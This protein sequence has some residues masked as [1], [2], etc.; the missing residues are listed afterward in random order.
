[1]NYKKIIYNIFY[2]ILII[3]LIII[4]LFLIPKNF[5][6]NKQKIKSVISDKTY[7]DLLSKTLLY[8][9]KRILKNPYNNEKLKDYKYIQKGYCGI[10]YI[11]NNKTKYILKSYT[12]LNSLKNDDAILTHK[13]GCGVCSTLQDLA[14]Y[15]KHKN[16]TSIIK[17]CN[18]RHFF[19]KKK[20]KKCIQKKLNFTKPCFDIW[21]YDNLNAKKKCIIPCL[22]D[23]TSSYVNKNNKLNRCL[24]CD[25]IKNGPIFKKIAGRNRRN[26]GITSSI[27]RNFI[28]N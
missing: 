24:K 8:P 7:N 1:M 21:W 16:L 19:S 12:D 3:I 4:L 26:S 10:K 25:E 14:V 20:I 6:Y 28:Y 23:Y 13:G 18:I 5:R 2:Y 9:Y 27:N 15:K 22:W 17:K 11:D